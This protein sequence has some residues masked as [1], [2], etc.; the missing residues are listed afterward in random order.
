MDW[1]NVM[2]YDMAGNWTDY[3]GHNAPLFPS[4][5]EPGGRPHSTATT[6]A[7]LLDDRQIPA[8]RLA[9]GIP[10]Y[11]RGFA[12][13]APYASTKGVARARIP[14]GNYRNL[15]RLHKEEGWTRVW[16]DETKVPWLIAPDRS[17]VIGYDDAESVALKTEWA[18][19]R[20]FRGVFYWQVSADRLPDGTH[21]L[22]EAARREWDKATAREK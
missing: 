3:A 21:P 14:E 5:K 9:V 6:M 22:Q 12:V 7:F 20:G 13:S 19:K 8:D 2:T 15:H 4:S 11:G 17:M 16:D 18:M 1:I 10:L